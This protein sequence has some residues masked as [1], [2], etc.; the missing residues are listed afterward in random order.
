MTWKYQI[1][2]YRDGSGYG[3]HEVYYDKNGEPWGMTED[4]VRFGSEENLLEIVDALLMAL[5]ETERAPAFDEPETWPG[6]PP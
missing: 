5:R 6:R 2:R 1:V 4:P 3:L